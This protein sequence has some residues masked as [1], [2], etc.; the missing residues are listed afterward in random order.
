MPGLAPGLAVEIVAARRI[1]VG[2]RRQ[3]HAVVR[4]T[5]AWGVPV[6]VAGAMALAAPWALSLFTQAARLQARPHC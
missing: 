6:A 1:G 2:Q 5:L 4:R 3:A